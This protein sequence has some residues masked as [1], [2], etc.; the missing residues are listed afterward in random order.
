MACYQGTD[1]LHTKDGFTALAV[2][3]PLK[4]LLFAPLPKPFNYNTAHG[5]KTYHVQVKD[6]KQLAYIDKENEDRATSR[7]ENITKSAEWAHFVNNCSTL[8]GE[9]FRVGPLCEQELAQSSSQA[10]WDGQPSLW[11]S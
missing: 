7:E 4:Q 9:S 11:V 1:N 3:R 6:G 2:V 10:Q 8:A 5:D